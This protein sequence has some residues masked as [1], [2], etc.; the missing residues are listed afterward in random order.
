MI[1][2]CRC[3]IKRIQK[4]GQSLVTT[5]VPETTCGCIT[6]VQLELVLTMIFSNPSAIGT[7]TTLYIG[8]IVDKCRCRR[9]HFACSGLITESCI[10]CNDAGEDCKYKGHLRG[11]RNASV[12]GAQSRQEILLNHVV[13][14]LRMAL[15]SIGWNPVAKEPRIIPPKTP[16]DDKPSIPDRLRG[17]LKYDLKRRGDVSFPCDISILF[18]F[19]SC[20]R[21]YHRHERKS[22]LVQ[23]NSTMITKWTNRHWRLSEYII[24]EGD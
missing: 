8:Y 24:R 15:N 11:D 20:V 22:G 1:R 18:L 21:S 10:D 19:T 9:K 2:I 6:E 14:P 5:T 4:A 17:S 16:N 7:W 3:G 23:F 12:S 13:K